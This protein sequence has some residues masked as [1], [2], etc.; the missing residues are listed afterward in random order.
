VAKPS[1]PEKLGTILAQLRPVEVNSFPKSTI[2]KFDPHFY[3]SNGAMR[4]N[5]RNELD[6]LVIDVIGGLG[7]STLQLGLCRTAICCFTRSSRTR[8]FLDS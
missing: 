6:R 1:P 2:E 5:P 4:P 8:S 7:E 3:L